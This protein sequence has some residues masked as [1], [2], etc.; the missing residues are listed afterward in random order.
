MVPL[1][2]RWIPMA[3][4]KYCQVIN[5]LPFNS[6]FSSALVLKEMLQFIYYLIWYLITVVSTMANIE[7]RTLR[8][9]KAI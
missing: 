9:E 8:K 3:D 7:E 6:K 1:I 2:S 5:I 4:I